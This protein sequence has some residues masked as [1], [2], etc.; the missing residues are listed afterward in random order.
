VGVG[1]GGVVTLYY[2]YAPRA[3]SLKIIDPLLQTACTDS[4]PPIADRHKIYLLSKVPPLADIQKCLRTGQLLAYS[5]SGRGVQPG[6]GTGVEPG[7]LWS[8]EFI[9][10]I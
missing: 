7:I 8:Q 5:G 6:R 3:F 2:N 10:F 1:V 9:A 4:H